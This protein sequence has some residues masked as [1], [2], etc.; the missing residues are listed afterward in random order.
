MENIFLFSD[1]RQDRSAIWIIKILRKG[2]WVWI[3]RMMRPSRMFLILYYNL[4]RKV[5]LYLAQPP[6]Q[7]WTT[8]KMLPKHV[9]KNSFNLIVSLIVNTQLNNVN[10]IKTQQKNYHVISECCVFL[11]VFVCA[12]YKSLSWFLFVAKIF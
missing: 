5:P 1:T 6:P 10:V 8:T 2:T 7:F 9:H 12:I 11:S 3:S 4:R